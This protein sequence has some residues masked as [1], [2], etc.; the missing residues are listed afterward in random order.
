MFNYATSTFFCNYASDNVCCIFTG[1]EVVLSVAGMLAPPPNNFG[2]K[3]LG[4]PLKLGSA[5]MARFH[6]L[7]NLAIFS[8][9]SITS[10]VE[11]PVFHFNEIMK[12]PGTSFHSPALSQKHIR[13]IRHT[14]YYMTK[15]HFYDA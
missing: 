15:F 14:A 9:F 7:F 1:F 12:R 11:V 5:T 6:L 13:N 3:F 4:P 2:L 10:Y 8:N